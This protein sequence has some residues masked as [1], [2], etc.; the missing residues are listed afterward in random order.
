MQSAT[1]VLLSGGLA[2]GVPL[3]LAV[4]EFRSLGSRNGRGHRPDD[5]DPT[6][7]PPAPDHPPAATS[8]KPL[9]GCLIPAPMVRRPDQPVRELEPA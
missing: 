9:P 8:R 7:T 4:R 6:P 2:F 5:G 3:Y 1:L